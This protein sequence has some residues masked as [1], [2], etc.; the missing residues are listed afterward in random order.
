VPV[1]NLGDGSLACLD[2]KSGGGEAGIIA[3]MPGVSA[4]DQ[5]PERLAS[6]F[7]AYFRERIEAEI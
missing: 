2:L 6:D 1:E 5:D 7:G 3:F 4:E